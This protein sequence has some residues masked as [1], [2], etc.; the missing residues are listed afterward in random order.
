M[1]PDNNSAPARKLVLAAALL[2]LAALAPGCAGK[3]PVGTPDTIS[4]DGL[5]RQAVV[6]GKP[7]RRF[8]EIAVESMKLDPARAVMV[9]DDIESDVGGAQAAGLK[10]ILTRTGKYRPELIERS[11]VKPDAVIDS[12][13]DLPSLFHL[14]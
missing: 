12:I 13:A 6:I 5:S 3:G 4:A 1:R 2:A 14:T 10:G 8:F 7:S 11:T 9:G